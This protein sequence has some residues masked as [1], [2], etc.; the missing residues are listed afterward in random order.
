M[1]VRWKPAYIA[2]GSNLEDPER[3]VR[4]AFDALAGLP[5][6][7]LVLHSRLYASAP[8]GPVDQPDYVNA[9]AGL[10]T[11]QAAPELLES[12]QRIEAQQNRV[13]GPKWG[14]RTLDLDLLLF[15]REVSDDPALTL[16]HPG[17][18]RRNFVL[19]PLADIAPTLVVPGHGRVSDMAEACGT[20]GLRLFE[21]NK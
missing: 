10:V 17:L 7:R 2:L 16:P 12:L 4:T 15:G 14:P 6:T 13:R 1:A 9:V 11:R 8:I 18:H 19:Y 3:Q 21:N 5:G 20:D